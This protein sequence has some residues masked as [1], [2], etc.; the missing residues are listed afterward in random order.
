M[1]CRRGHAGAGRRLPFCYPLKHVSY[2]RPEAAIRQVVAVRECDG[3][4]RYRA[5]R[6]RA[7]RWTSL[8]SVRLAATARV[9]GGI[10]RLALMLDGE[11]LDTVPARRRPVR[12]NVSRT[13][14]R[15]GRLSQPPPHRAAD[16]RMPLENPDRI[17]GQIRRSARR[18]RMFGHQEIEQPIEIGRGSAADASPS[19][20]SASR[21][22][23]SAACASKASIIQACG[24]LPVAAAGGTIR[25]LSAWGSLRVVV[26]VFTAALVDR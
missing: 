17:D 6:N 5:R 25:A 9:S 21:I 4:S 23:A 16:V 26:E 12:R 14:M 15:D 8:L 24:V 20:I 1:H 11:H 19:A 18:S 22:S 3:G 10:P 7:K 2:A 13:T